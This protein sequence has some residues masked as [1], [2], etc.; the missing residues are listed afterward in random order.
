ML[1]HTHEISGYRDINLPLCPIK[2][3]RYWS[4]LSATTTDQN[5][6][7]KSCQS[8]QNRMAA[9][10]FFALHVNASIISSVFAA[11]VKLN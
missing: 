5:Y 10:K 1:S 3:L 7:K 11:I 8:A 6:I 4:H 2:D 9:A